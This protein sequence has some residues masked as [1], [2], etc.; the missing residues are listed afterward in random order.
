MSLPLPG[1]FSADAGTITIT[2][3]T[4]IIIIASF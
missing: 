2:I 4:I 1:N 3:I